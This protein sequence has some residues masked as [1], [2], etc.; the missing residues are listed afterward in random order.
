MAHRDRY[1]AA[2]KCPLLG[3]KRPSLARVRNVETTLNGLGAGPV[4][5]LA[6]RLLPISGGWRWSKT[7][8]FYD[9][10]RSEINLCR[11]DAYAIRWTCVPRCAVCGDRVVWH[12]LR[13]AALAD[14]DL[15]SYAFT[16][17]GRIVLMFFL[18]VSHSPARRR[19][20]KFLLTYWGY[21]N[22]AGPSSEP[23]Q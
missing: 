17:L 23:R 3:V 15:V 4:A 16:D 14:R 22:L 13:S 12:R 10:H 2:T 8:Q 20:R 7:Q 18:R 5:M 21:Q 11:L 19:S 6:P 9:L 1:C